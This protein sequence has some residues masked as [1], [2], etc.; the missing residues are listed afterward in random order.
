[1]TN[2]HHHS[3]NST[4]N[5]GV[6]DAVFRALFLF[7]AT[8]TNSTSSERTMNGAQHSITNGAQMRLDA[9]VCFIL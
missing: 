7:F 2:G 8:T 6:R 9:W 5:A 4:E 3:C 1:M